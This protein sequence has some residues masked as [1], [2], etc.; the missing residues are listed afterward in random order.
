M[1]YSAFWLLANKSL[2][3]SY[4]LQVCVNAGLVPLIVVILFFYTSF[5]FSYFTD[6]VPANGMCVGSE[7][8]WVHLFFCM[9]M[10]TRARE[11]SMIVLVLVTL[12]R[13]HKGYEWEW[14]GNVPMYAPERIVMPFS[15]PLFS[16]ETDSGFLGRLTWNK[17][18]HWSWLIMV[19]I[20]PMTE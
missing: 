11:Y 16:Q 20:F 12:S 13:V 14:M 17:A 7:C 19:E 18:I 3:Q 4:N 8:V 2:L 5:T 10:W 1:S 6:S 15:S 9:C